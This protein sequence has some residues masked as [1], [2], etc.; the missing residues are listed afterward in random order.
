MQAI[1][2]GHQCKLATP[3]WLSTS[4]SLRH[5]ASVVN[6]LDVADLMW[7]MYLM[8]LIWCGQCTWCCWSDVVNVLDVADLMWSMY[9]MFGRSSN[10]HNHWC[11]KSQRECL[12]YIH[13]Q[14]ALSDEASCWWCQR[15][16]STIPSGLS[17][18]L[19]PILSLRNKLVKSRPEPL[20]EF[21]T[22]STGNMHKTTTCKNYI[23]SQL[24]N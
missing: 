12:C 3:T 6:V 18:L 11:T 24:N 19:P 23:P 4:C 22:G 13:S 7:S 8:L 14:T 15:M 20:P 5:E 10:L 2:F 16:G 21:Q 9:L 1:A 17:V